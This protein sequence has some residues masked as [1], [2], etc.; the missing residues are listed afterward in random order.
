MRR[1][2]PA[3]V[4]TAAAPGEGDD[5]MVADGNVVH[6]RSHRLNH[7]R[8]L[9]PEH[10]GVGHAW[11]ITVAPVQI[12]VAHAGR[13]DANPHLV[14]TG[15]RQFKG[16]DHEWC[17]PVTHY[18]GCDLH[19]D[20]VLVDLSRNTSTES[21]WTPRFADLVL[22]GL[23]LWRAGSRDYLVNLLRKLVSSW[24]LQ[25]SHTSSEMWS[26]CTYALLRKSP[27]LYGQAPP[28]AKA[29]RAAHRAERR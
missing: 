8:T 13:H 22:G 25:V 27:G 6:L 2:L 24:V 26:S 11:K 10:R 5:D 3:A 28:E 20:A 18:C 17:G 1:H 21:S 12:R 9:V 15:V 29:T 14:G 16:L 23:A 4:R 19:V 7:A